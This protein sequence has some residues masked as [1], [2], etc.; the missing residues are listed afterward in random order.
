MVFATG[1]KIL[2]CDEKI[3]CFKCGTKLFVATQIPKR[4]VCDKCQDEHK[5]G[6]EDVE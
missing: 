5:E 2:V 4:Y 3:E 1:G 6:T